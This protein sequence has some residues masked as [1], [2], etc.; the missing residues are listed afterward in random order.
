LT[1][2]AGTIHLV[3]HWSAKR[4]HC[5]YFAIAPRKLLD[6]QVLH[7]DEVDERLN[8]MDFKISNLEERIGTEFADLRKLLLDRL[9]SP[10]ARSAPKVASSSTKKADRI[11][12]LTVPKSKKR[13]RVKGEDDEDDEDNDVKAAHKLALAVRRK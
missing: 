13:K 7:D 2:R 5:T 6:D 8:Q 12:G 1:T 9:P 10:G 4:L 11:D 3:S